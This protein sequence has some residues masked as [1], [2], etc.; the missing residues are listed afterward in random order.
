[1]QLEFAVHTGLR[2]GEL[3]ELRW[4]DIEFAKRTVVKVRR[5]VGNDGTV[6]APKSKQGLRDI[7][8]PPRIA[9]AL[10]RRQEGT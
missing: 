10:F 2:I 3:V 1:M 4:R 8:L 6:S 7:P 9:S 5:Q